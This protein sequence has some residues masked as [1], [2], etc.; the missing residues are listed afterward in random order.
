M[1]LVDGFSSLLLVVASC[2]AHEIIVANC[3]VLGVIVM[4]TIGCWF[5]MPIF[6]L[7]FL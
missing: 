2:S 7:G 6:I 1:E 5:M 3:D 4:L